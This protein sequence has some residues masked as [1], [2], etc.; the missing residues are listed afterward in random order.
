MLGEVLEGDAFVGVESE[1]TKKQL[2]EGLGVFLVEGRVVLHFHFLQV[3][4]FVAL[5]CDL[6]L[7]V[8]AY[9]T[10]DVLLKGKSPKS[11]L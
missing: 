8:D 9:L 2:S 4:A 6:V 10:T 3:K 1:D 5:R 7:H 11:I